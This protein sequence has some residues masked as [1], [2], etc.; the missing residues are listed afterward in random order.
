MSLFLM[1][2]QMIN[3]LVDSN[4]DCLNKYMNQINYEKHI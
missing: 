1:L 3:I 4:N 2:Y